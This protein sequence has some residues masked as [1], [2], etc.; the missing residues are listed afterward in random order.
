ML[1]ADKNETMG[2]DFEEFLNALYNSKNDLIDVR[3]LKKL[4]EMGADRHGFDMET[5]ITQ[6]RRAKLFN[7]TVNQV[8]YI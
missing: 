4:Q 3:K 1:N 6:E 7:S 2:L 8:S 5:L